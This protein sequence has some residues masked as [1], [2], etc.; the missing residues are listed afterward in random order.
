MS[1]QTNKCPNC[2]G[3]L[4]E[5]DGKQYCPHCGGEYSNNT[6]GDL[7][8]TAMATEYV[9]KKN[10]TS[11]R[12]KQH[13]NQAV[14]EYYAGNYADCKYQL[15]RV[16]DIDPNNDDANIIKSLLTK[17]EN[18]RY[19]SPPGRKI[20]RAIKN[21][22][23]DEDFQRTEYVDSLFLSE[24][25]SMIFISLYNIFS[26][27]KLFE[28]SSYQNKNKFLDALNKLLSI[29]IIVKAVFWTLV[30]ILF[31]VVPNCNSSSSNKSITVKYYASTGGTVYIQSED[32]RYREYYTYNVKAGTPT[33]AEAVPYSGYVF[34]KWSD[35]ITYASRQDTCYSNK[36]VTAYFKLAPS[37]TNTS[38]TQN[39]SLTYTASEGG[40]I[41]GNSS[42]KVY[43][44]NSGTEVTAIPNL[45]Y[46]FV[47]WNDGLTET[48]RT[49]GNCTKD[50][51]YIAIFEKLFES[52]DGSEINPFEIANL[53]QLVNL[54]EDCSGNR[55]YA[56]KYFVLNNNIDLST[57][58][59][60]KG[61]SNFKG[62]FDG[63]NKTI[64]NLK[65]DVSLST[66]EYLG[67]FGYTKS[68]T[69]KNLNVQVSI[70]NEVKSVLTIYCGGICGLANNTNIINCSSSGSINIIG[71]SD[72][73]IGGIVGYM[74]YG[75][76]ESCSSTATLDGKTNN[77]L[78]SEVSI[79]E[80]YG[81]KI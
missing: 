66:S 60:W 34:S 7:L 48:K 81:N 49:E 30:I 53:T 65:I 33:Y 42:Q 32:T 80:L 44:G 69:I 16:L 77:S 45:G 52:G 47:K 43:S 6:L 8:L 62:I 50:V 21:W 57:I 9:A 74:S 59:N 18:G 15:N 3:T 5:K 72:V 73:Y 46:K 12:A 61:I 56:N 13:L 23:E 70:I 79:G 36:S 55:P 20:V 38:T 64:S 75:D 76:I 27:K 78:Y 31:A 22:I 37:S 28:Q 11:N 68:A 58:D 1:E 24:L 17:G 14:H 26:L 67:L 40:Y 25:S 4:E 19:V 54:M 10:T 29:K 41:L 63:N 39:I 71:N 35:G 51:S 2:G